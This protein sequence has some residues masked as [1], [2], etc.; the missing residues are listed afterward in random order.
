MMIL[1]LLLAITLPVCEVEERPDLQII[2]APGRIVPLARVN[3]V[4]QV[5]GEILEVCFRNGALVKEGDVLYKLDAARYEAAYKNAQSKVAE[6]KANAAYAELSYE[7]HQK[8]LGTR[9]VSEDAV[10]NAL[11]VRDASRAAYAAAEAALIVA[12][13][14]L[15]RC[16]IK[17][18]ISGK[19]GTTAMTRGNYAK[20]GGDP[21]VSIVQ[22]T[23]IRVAFSISNSRFLDYFGGM[24]RRLGAEADASL[25]LANGEPYGQVGQFEY[26]DNTANELTDTIEVFFKYDNSAGL[27]RPGGVVT[28]ALESKV[29]AMRPVV[30]PAAVL[31]DVQGAYVWVV[32]AENQAERRSIARGDLIGDRV[33]VEKGLKAGERVVAEGAHKVKRGMTIEAAQ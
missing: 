4:P 33:V 23:P 11:S 8:L 24:S 1:S 16:V 22:F 31:Q 15:N 10:D 6:T 2:Y 3:I 29:G 14:D 13:E 9:A 25:I 17:A 32:T 27:L 12:K 7:R 20:A 21:L 28:V 5:S 30:P 19:I 26:V 18:P